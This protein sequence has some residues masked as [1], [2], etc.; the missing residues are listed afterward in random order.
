MAAQW[1]GWCPEDFWQATPS[2]LRRALTAP[3]T[4]MSGLAPSRDTIEQ[5]LERD[6]N[7]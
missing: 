4:P 5:M 7:G 1:L 3:E 2:E 6:S